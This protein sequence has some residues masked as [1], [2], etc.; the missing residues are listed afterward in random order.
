MTRGASRL[1]RGFSGFVREVN[2]GILVGYGLRATGVRSAGGLVKGSFR[3][4]GGP[5]AVSG[6]ADGSLGGWISKVG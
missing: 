3:R 5:G 4:R 1:I 2:R 6:R